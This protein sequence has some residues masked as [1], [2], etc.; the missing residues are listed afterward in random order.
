[1]LAKPEKDSQRVGHQKNETDHGREAVGIA[2]ARDS[3][4]LRNVWNHAAEHHRSSWNLTKLY[5][6]AQEKKY[7]LNEE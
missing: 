3:S 4:I 1:M 2:R 5:T 7:P 6:P